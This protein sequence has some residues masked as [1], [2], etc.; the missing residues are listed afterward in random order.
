MEHPIYDGAEGISRP[1][2]EESVMSDGT[3]WPA[4][5]DMQSADTDE[6]I[7]FPVHLLPGAVRPFVEKI[8]ELKSATPDMIA[9]PA[10]IQAGA[11]LGKDVLIQVMTE[12]EDWTER[13]CLWGAIIAPPGS[14]KSPAARMALKPIAKIQAQL[15][16]QWLDRIQA[17]KDAETYDPKCPPRQEVVYY[18]SSTGE[19]VVELMSPDFNFGGARGLL[20]HR[21]ELSGWIKSMNQYRQGVG[22]DRQ[23]YLQAYSGDAISKQLVKGVVNAPDPFLC[24]FGTIQPEVAREVFGKTAED[25]MNARFG[26]VAVPKWV[27]PKL[28]NVK[29][30]VRVK[31]E[32]N[33]AMLR[34]REVQA[35]TVKFD[36]EAYAIFATWYEKL[37]SRPEF[38]AD[39]PF[40]YHITKYQSLFPRLCLVFHF[41]KHGKDAPELVHAKTAEAVRDLIDTYLEPHARRLY[42]V[43]GEH[44]LHGAASK[45]AGWIVKEGKRKFRISDIRKK[46]WQT[47]NRDD[48]VKFIERTL[49]YL[50]DHDWIEQVQAPQ[51]A[52]GG[53]PTFDWVVNP[54][55][56]QRGLRK[57]A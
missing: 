32:Y 47:F 18:N 10:L 7:P 48:D 57:A 45:I 54:R 22:D 44:V 1:S 36:P 28:V 11:L 9:I 49:E 50:Q 12:N 31:E 24:I 51:T 41:L 19:R 30:D 5:A 13:P 17:E 14:M 21:D 23:I 2:G 34:L 52:A 3:P 6:E 55:V 56:H 26:L 39:N 38:E 53:R 42:G 25:G 27:K 8:A 33:K 16:K 46:K 43:V 15:D 40:A 37:T 35:R 29:A 4:P 20:L